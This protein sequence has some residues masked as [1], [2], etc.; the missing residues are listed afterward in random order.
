M[1]IKAL[2]SI[3][4]CV[5]GFFA[6]SAKADTVVNTS[7]CT[8]SLAYIQANNYVYRS[9]CTGVPQLTKRVLGPVEGCLYSVDNPA[10]YFTNTTCTSYTLN[11]KTPSTPLTACQASGKAGKL[12]TADYITV[13]AAVRAASYCAPQ[14]GVY[15]TMAGGYSYRYYC[16]SQ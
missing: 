10:Y 5:L 6:V 7:G 13:N 3:I 4:F 11:F 15:S 14:C 2:L 16:S 9:V 12:V 1:K 8:W